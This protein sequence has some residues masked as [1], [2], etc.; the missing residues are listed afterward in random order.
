MISKK[1]DNPSV[2]FYFV[3]NE[4]KQTKSYKNIYRNIFKTKELK[5]LKMNLIYI[6]NSD[7]LIKICNNNYLLLK[8]KNFYKIPLCLYSI[9]VEV[10][11][12]IIFIAYRNLRIV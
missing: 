1:T 6:S 4:I 9:C 3:N 2:F 12:I 7:I 10:L 8:E 5:I 11:I